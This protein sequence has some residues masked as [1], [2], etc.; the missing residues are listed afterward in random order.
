MNTILNTTLAIDRN[1]AVACILCDNTVIVTF[2]EI[3]FLVQKTADPYLFH[4]TTCMAC[5]TKIERANIYTMNHIYMNEDGEVCIPPY[6]ESD[7][8]SSSDDSMPCLP[9]ALKLDVGFNTPV[10]INTVISMM[11]YRRM[12]IHL[13]GYL[14]TYT[15]AGRYVIEIVKLIEPI[16]GFEYTIKSV[17]P[18][19]RFE[20]I[21][22]SD[23]SEMA[24]DSEGM[25]EFD[26]E[27]GTFFSSIYK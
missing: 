9:A 12:S 24:T 6:D 7:W 5:L 21:L 18:R 3:Q 11:A 19:R 16:Q 14:R 26:Y 4:I 1:T 22:P 15:L 25:I 27:D 23:R 13:N 10:G 8:N 20:K 17:I 2:D